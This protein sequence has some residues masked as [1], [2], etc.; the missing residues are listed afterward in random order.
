[1]LTY[2][3]YAPLFRQ[4][5]VQPGLKIERFSTVEWGTW[6]VTFFL[7]INIDGITSQHHRI[8]KQRS[9]R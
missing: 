9:T 5:F 1:M 7:F 8:I 3:V 2:S 6:V 4:F